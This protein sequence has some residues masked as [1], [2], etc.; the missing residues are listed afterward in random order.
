MILRLLDALGNIT[1]RAC[2][3]IGSFCVF[4]GRVVKVLCTTR[5]NIRQV[6]I[7]MHHIGVES[8]TIVFLTGISI[9]L[10]LALQ[11]YIGFHR[12]GADMFIGLVVALGIARELGPVLTGIMV[13]GRCG[14]AMAAEIGT[15]QITEQIDALKT[16][17]INPYQYLI[18]PR[19]VASSV[20]LPFLTIFS[21]FCGI[22]GGYFLC[23]YQLHLNPIDFM[24]IIKERMVLNDLIGGLIK[25]FFFGI[26]LSCVG[27]YNGYITHGGARGV[28]LATTRSVVAGS[29]L[30]LVAN[31]LLSSLLF[32]AGVG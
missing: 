23:V 26:I 6:I 2:T 17:C 14:S 28:G 12:L 29:I 8:F 7:Q 30:I 24:S 10:A 22:A 15:M 3:T 20:M 9:G 19:I 1:L 4:T 16:L 5:L 21:V 13:T 11:T 27:T 18:V 32:Q 25:S 31:Y